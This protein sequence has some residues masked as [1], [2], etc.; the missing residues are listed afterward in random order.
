MQN[1][2]CNAYKVLNKDPG[3]PKVLHTCKLSMISL[4]MLHLAFLS[5]CTESLCKSQVVPEGCGWDPGLP[6]VSAWA[7]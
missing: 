5:S 3:T 1:K 2:Q 4:P 6:Q 7:N